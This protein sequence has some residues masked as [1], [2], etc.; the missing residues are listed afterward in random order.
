MAAAQPTHWADIQEK[1]FT[2]WCNNHLE[3][4]GLR[5]NDFKTDWTNGLLLINLIEII[6]HPKK[7]E[8]YNKHPRIPLQKTE[9]VNI[10]LDFL[11]NE[12]IKL[13]NIG[14]NDIVK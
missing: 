3:E 12:G 2:R 10:A 6:S 8:R 7:I 4:R 5:I 9:N 13:V 14:G 1:A 11:K